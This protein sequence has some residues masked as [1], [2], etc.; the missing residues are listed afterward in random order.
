MRRPSATVLVCVGLVVLTVA[1]YGPLWRNN[2]INFDDDTW[3]TGNPNVNAG[4][5]PAEIRRAWTEFHEGYWIPLTWMSLQLDVSLSPE[6][7]PGGRRVPSAIICHAQNLFWHTANVVLLFWVLRRMTGA[8]WRSAAVAA[9]FA[10]HPMHVE[11]VAWATERKDVLSTFFLLLTMLAYIDYTERPGVWRYFLVLGTYVLGLLA[12]PMLVTLPCALLL[13]DYWPLRRIGEWRVMSDEGRKPLVSR[14]ASLAILL[15]EKVPLLL[16]AAGAS[17]VMIAAQRSAHA[18]YG[19]GGLTV[20]ARLANAVVS[21]GWY[22]ETTFWPTRLGL[23]YPHAGENW[24][25]APVLGWAA[26]LVALTVAALAV[27]RRWPWLTVGW[28]WFLGTMV[29]VIGLVQAGAQGRAD[30]YTYVPHIGLFVAL[31]WGGAALL[32]RLRVPAV[33]QAVVASACLAILAVLTSGQ[34]EFWRDP[35]TL[36]EHTLTVTSH[37]YRAHFNLANYLAGR[38]LNEKDPALLGRAAEQYRRAV[39]IQAEDFRLRHNFGMLLLI[40]GDADRAVREFA[41]AARQNPR[42]EDALCK[43][44]AAQ[45]EAGKAVEA[46]QSLLRALALNPRSPVPRALLGTA[47]WRQGQGD[48]AM[49]QW[50][51]AVRANPNEPEALTGLALLMLQKQHPEGAVQALQVALQVE[52]TP[53]RL[54]LRGVALGRMGHWHEAAGAHGQAV[55]AEE[56]RQALL[57]KPTCSKLA[58]YRRRLGYALYAGRQTAAA[59]REYAAANDLDPRWPRTAVARAWRLATDPDEA[60]RDPDEAL[61]LAGQACQ[62]EADPPAE[63]LDALAAAQAAAGHYD[64]AAATARRAL[65]KASP[66]QVKPIGARVQL[67]EHGKPFVAGKSET[68]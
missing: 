55:A 25:W 37:N 34:V 66:G 1:A 27:A 67:Y 44:A 28:L 41:E 62:A 4:L 7:G 68:P 50:Q 17:M 29:P 65:G 5:K 8:V 64:E 32:S 36:W 39:A 42:D 12:K 19:L 56:S 18:L 59:A 58:L 57:A 3:I 24:Q 9:L 54:S 48:A 20:P 16:A 53:L 6:H 45:L 40:R 10:V 23:F 14:H 43:L 13:L 15:L 49:S 46:E 61:E 52:P 35:G 22:L 26:V 31:V 63:A 30:R 2:F 60:A 38:G 51:T 21:Y 11:S 47:L 33:A